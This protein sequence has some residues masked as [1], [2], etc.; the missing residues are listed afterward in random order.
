MRRLD[1][2]IVWV[3]D[4]IQE[5]RAGADGVAPE[6]DDHRMSLLLGLSF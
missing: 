3:W 1:L 4:R 5:P 6:R 2:D